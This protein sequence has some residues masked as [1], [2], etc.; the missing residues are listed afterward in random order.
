[1]QLAVPA[2][3]ASGVAE[4]GRLYLPSSELQLK[5]HVTQLAP[6]ADKTC[7]MHHAAVCRSV[8]TAVMAALARDSVTA[9]H[10]PE[11]AIDVW[12]HYARRERELAVDAQ[13]MTRQPDLNHKFRTILVD[14]LIEVQIRLRLHDVTLSLA[15]ALV[16]AFLSRQ[17]V[18]RDKLQLIGVAALFTA[19][20]FEEV[21]GPDANSLVVISSKAFTR[22]DIV[23]MQSRMLQKVEFTI[24]RPTATWFLFRLLS[25]VQPSAMHSWLAQYYVTYCLG[26]GA[27]M[28][29]HLPSCVATAA[30]YLSGMRLGQLAPHVVDV[31]CHISTYDIATPAAVA[32]MKDMCDVLG[33]ATTASAVYKLYSTLSKCAVSTITVPTKPDVDACVQRHAGIP[34]PAS[35]DKEPRDPG[36][37]IDSGGAMCG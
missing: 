27:T 3:A 28:L 25:V 14:W 20:H 35:D 23:Q 24:C 9:S 36:L 8:S 6:T 5:Q 16:D 33:S 10:V 30:V 26:Q 18:Y 19:A 21:H 29:R 2:T 13:Y 32:C 22:A 7:A 37:V 4:A 31:I 12:E 1:M 34:A 15:V 11:Y 17:L